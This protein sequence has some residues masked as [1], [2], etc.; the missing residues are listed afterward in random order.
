MNT[1]ATSVRLRSRLTLIAIAAMFVAPI[2]V[3]WLFSTGTLD[4]HTR[5]LVNRGELL[6]PPI[7]LGTERARPG[8]APLFKLAPSEWAMVYLEPAACT[9]SCAAHLD[10]LL[11]IREL[12]GQGAVRVSVHAIAAAAGPAG[13]HA[14]RIHVDAEALGWLTRE[15]IAR[16]SPPP[17]P[18][19]M[20]VDWRHQ[21]MLRYPSDDRSG[22]QKDLKRLL[23]ASAIR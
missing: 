3:A 17:L 21:M 19:V 9:E 12:L 20:L 2:V 15:L 7:D 5:K 14:A 1:E 23:R 10:E 13:P 16:Q 4:L 11:V 18:A 6:S 22:I 8:F